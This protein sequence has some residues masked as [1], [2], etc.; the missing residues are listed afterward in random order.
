MGSTTTWS[1]ELFPKA[2]G[3]KLQQPCF[4]IHMLI[5]SNSLQI[6]H[7]KSFMGILEILSKCII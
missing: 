5:C 2:C 6:E 1:D 4:Y 3:Q 7:K